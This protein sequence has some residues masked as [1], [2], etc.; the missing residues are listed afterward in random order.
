MRVQ[1][2]TATKTRVHFGEMDEPGEDSP[3][4]KKWNEI[5]DGFYSRRDTLETDYR[6]GEISWRKLNRKLRKLENQEAACKECL[7]NNFDINMKPI[8]REVVQKENFFVRLF[9]ALK[10]V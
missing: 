1:L 7:E 2:A 8:I 10:S 4:F 6:N 5:N 3:K 9:K